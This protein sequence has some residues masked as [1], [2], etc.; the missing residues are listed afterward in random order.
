MIQKPR[1]NNPGGTINPVMRQQFIHQYAPGNHSGKV[2]LLFSIYVLPDIDG[3]L[4]PEEDRQ[5]LDNSTM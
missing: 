3:L 2:S 5:H 1:G 4:D